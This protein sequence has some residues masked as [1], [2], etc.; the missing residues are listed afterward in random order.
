MEEKKERRP[1]KRMSRRDFIKNSG[2]VAAGAVLAS[3]MFKP[4]KALFAGKDEEEG[5]AKMAAGERMKVPLVDKNKFSGITLNWLE[6]T[7]WGFTTAIVNPHIVE[8]CGVSIGEKEVFK[9]GEGHAKIVPQLL[10]SKPRWDWMEF[11]PM[12]MGDFVNMDALEPLDDY[13]AQYE[14]TEEYLDQVMPPFREFQMKRFGKVYSLM[15]DGDIHVMHTRPSFFNDPDLKRKFERR[16]KRELKPAETWQEY[17]DTTQFFTEETPDGIYGGQMII[18]PPN[19]GWSW[20]FDVAAGNGVRYFDEGMNPAITS[21]EAE[22]ALEL[23]LEIMKFTP[24]GYESMD[25]MQSIKNWQ[26]GAIV[27]SPWFIDLPEYSARQAPEIAED[28]GMTIMP[29]WKKGNEIVHRTMM[30]YGRTLAIPKKIPQEKK[31]AAFYFIYRI[32]HMDYSVH[33]VADEFS[34][35]DPYMRIHYETPEEYIKADPLRGITDVWTTNSGIFRTLESAK[36]YLDGGLANAAVGY[37]QPD[38]TGAVEFAESLGR[39]IGKA[40]TGE[41]K[42]MQALE[43]TAEEWTRIVQKYGIDNQKEQYRNFLA[44]AEKLGYA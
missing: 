6:D 43:T 39:N 2:K 24:P 41:L 36:A 30:V 10:T 25:I 44:T 35:S 22:E 1:S 26:A 31:D 23:F 34:G 38:W 19:F 11:S 28:Q 8:E 7:S 3:S 32:S 21:P 12:F 4:T 40:V 18:N 14:G 17:R 15:V 5:P 29:G 20:Y 13:L 9:L 37:S 16:F 27:T 42:S 33:Y